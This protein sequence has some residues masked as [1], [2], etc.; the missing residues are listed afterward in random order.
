MMTSRLSVRLTEFDSGKTAA[1]IDTDHFFR[2]SIRLRKPST[3][4][5]TGGW[6]LIRQG[7]LEMKSG[8]VVVAEEMVDTGQFQPH[9]GQ[10]RPLRKDRLE[11]SCGLSRMTESRRDQAEQKQ[12]LDALLSV[13][14]SCLLKQLASV[15]QPPDLE[16]ELSGLHFRDFNT[17][18]LDVLCIA[19]RGT[20]NEQGRDYNG[21][22]GEGSQFQISIPRSDSCQR[23]PATAFRREKSGQQLVAGCVC[24]F[25]DT[26]YLL[27]AG[28]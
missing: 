21:D 11:P 27:R 7:R 28:P 14:G 10:V 18:G 8:F 23:D 15:V 2:A 17:F 13:Y 25:E 16:E 1:D 26:A 5:S 3:A 9:P 19:W 6:Q 20:E 4:F 24:R 22:D 12:T